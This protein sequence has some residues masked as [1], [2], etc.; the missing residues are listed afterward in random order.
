MVARQPARA[1][2]LPA[3]APSPVARL[4]SAAAFGLPLIRHPEALALL[5]AHYDPG[6]LNE[7]RLRMANTPEGAE[8]IEN[9]VSHA[10][11]FRIGNVH[12][13]AGV[14]MIMQAMFEGLAPTL[15]GGPP[16]QS[17]SLRCGLPEGTLAAGLGAVQARY[18]EVDIGSYPSFKD[19]RA[20]VSVVLRSAEGDKLEAATEEVRALVRELGVEP[21]D[22]A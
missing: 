20:S 14:P 18:P 11:G 10:P 9:P 16:L 21:Q 13:M 6:D 8:L 5:E 15:V 17:R 4:W 7:A 22:A 19:G 12:V 2:S 3:T 1:R